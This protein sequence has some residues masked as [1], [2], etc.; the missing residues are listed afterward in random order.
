MK[1]IAWIVSAAAAVLSGCES[2]AGWR[3]RVAAGGGLSTLKTRN[4]G[5]SETASGEQASLRAE[6]ARPLEYADDV[7]VGLRVKAGRRTVDDD[8]GGIPYEFES[9]QLALLPTVRG[10]VPL[11]GASRLYGEAFVGYEQFW[12]EDRNGARRSTGTDGGVA[13]GAGAGVEFDIGSTR[14]IF[15]GLEW[16]RHDTKNF[17]VNLAFEDYS[18][19]VGLAFRF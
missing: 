6:I 12:G 14:A 16:A 5:Q 13:Y 3:G 11:S 15:V 7:D 1:P 8:F 10:Y 4:E 2:S 18:A 19:L 9:N 17:G